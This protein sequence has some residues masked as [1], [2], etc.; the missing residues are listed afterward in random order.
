MLTGLGG[1]AIK[2]GNIEAYAMSD[3]QLSAFLEAVK[4]DAWLEEKLKGA[5]DL[6]AAIAVAIAA[7]FDVSKAKWLQLQAKQAPKL[8][9]SQADPGMETDDEDELEEVAGGQGHPLTGAPYIAY[10]DC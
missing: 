7:G 2:I 3:E 6:D 1:G 4:A 9:E 5:A 10:E 8:S